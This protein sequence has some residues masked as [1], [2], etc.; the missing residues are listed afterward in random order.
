MRL[1]NNETKKYIYI[2]FKFRTNKCL[3]SF[4][5]FPRTEME[6]LIFINFF[7]TGFFS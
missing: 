6:N 5:K 7:Y 1:L 3:S 2:V 4:E